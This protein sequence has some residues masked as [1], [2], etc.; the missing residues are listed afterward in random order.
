MNSNS[1]FYFVL[2]AVSASIGLGNLFFYPYMSYKLTGFLFIPYIIAL[3]V[4]GIPLLLL[5]FSIGQY[6]NKNII[7]LFASIRGLSG[8]GWLM[9]VN[10]FVLVSAYAVMLSWH[11]IYFF[12]S[13]GLQWK[14]NAQKYFF[15]SVLQASDGIKNFTQFSL[16]VFVALVIAWGM[17]FICIRKG[18]ESVKKGFLIVFPIFTILMLFFLLYSLRLDSALAGIY[19]FLNPRFGNLLNFDVLI[20]SFYF[21]VLSLGLSFGIMPAVAGK[22]GKGFAVGNVFIV[23]FFKILISIAVGFIVF[24]I[25]GFLS[26][27]QGI[28]MGKLAPS[29]FG[30]V[31]TI[32]AQALP[33]FHRPTLIS[34]LFFAFFSIFVLFGAVA[35]AYSISHV[36]VH[37]FKTGHV[38]AAIIVSCIGFLSGLAFIIKPGFYIMDIAM[39]FIVYNVLIALLL[40]AIA[41]GWLFDSERLAQFISQ[42]SILKIGTLWRF[43]IRYAVPLILL[44]LLFIRIKSDY[45]LDYNNY[46]WWSI[47]I[48]G[49]GVVVAPLI[50]A[51]LLPQRILDRR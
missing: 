41:V 39:H 15:S 48:F 9:S 30:S 22:S 17:V 37:K 35:L 31:F 8:I 19:S 6:F 5:E 7:D 1:R 43:L 49:V 45:L 38:N 28:G 24:G 34:I 2:A 10:A 11:I 16:P 33:F 27:K 44:L 4:L 13:F 26:A 3:L 18:F 32:L 20:N 21:V 36:L 47:L 46:P 42:N 51:F 25:L 23:S 50:V 14:I 12:V 29:D 40:E